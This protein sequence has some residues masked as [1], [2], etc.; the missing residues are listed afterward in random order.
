VN[1]L[2]GLLLTDPDSL[3]HCTVYCQ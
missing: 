2:T 1:R 3:L